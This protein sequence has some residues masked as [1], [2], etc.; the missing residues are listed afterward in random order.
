MVELPSYVIVRMSGY[1]EQFDPSVERSEME[2]GPPKERVLNSQVLMTLN[3]SFLFETTDHEQAFFD[4]YRLTLKRIQRFTMQHPRTGEVITVK[5][6]G[7]NIGTLRSVSGTDHLWQR[8]L[9][10]EYMQ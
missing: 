8:D 3:L 6:L 1:S 5:F 7:G 10:V 9:S 2:R 4:W